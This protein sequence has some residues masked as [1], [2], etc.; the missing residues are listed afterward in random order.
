MAEIA[1]DWTIQDWTLTEEAAAMDT[2]RRIFQSTVKQ[3]RPTATQYCINASKTI[4][5]A[6]GFRTSGMKDGSRVSSYACSQFPHAVSDSVGAHTE[7]LQAAED[8]DSSN[9]DGDSQSTMTT[10]TTSAA[11]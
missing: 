11:K 8:R 7:A 6:D 4:E 1:G 2:E 9:G 10:R 3:H 5:T